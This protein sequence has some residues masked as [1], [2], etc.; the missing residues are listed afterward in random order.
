[1][2]NT[3]DR[4]L[5]SDHP[6]YVPPITEQGLTAAE[7]AE[8]WS[9]V[10]GDIMSTGIRAQLRESFGLCPRHTWGYAAVEIELWQQGAGSRG[11]H[12]PFDVGVLYA[13]LLTDVTQALEHHVGHSTRRIRGA[14]TPRDTCRICRNL[15]SE[16]NPILNVGYAGSNSERLAAEANRFLYTTE[17]CTQTLPM[18]TDRICPDCSHESTEKVFLCRQHLVGRESIDQDTVEALITRLRTLESHVRH[19][20]SSMT[21]K[22]EPATAEDDA[23]WI[24]TLGWFAGWSVP[25]ALT[26]ASSPSR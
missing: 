14:L 16:H 17:W 24:E 19:L 25:L 4:Q 13:D 1:M 20:V 6:S 2:H 7:V 3:A 8:L 18:W 10:H 22:G 23:S 26:D 11:G 5:P 12:Q 21:Q 15:Q 9:F